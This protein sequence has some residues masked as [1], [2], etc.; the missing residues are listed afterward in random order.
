MLDIVATDFHRAC[1][2]VPTITLDDNFFDS[3]GALSL[4]HGSFR[5]GPNCF[6]IC[7]MPALPP[8]K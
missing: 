7:F 5:A 1:C 2:L 8:A 4:V 3:L 6:N